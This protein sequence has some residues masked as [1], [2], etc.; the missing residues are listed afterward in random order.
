MVIYATYHGPAGTAEEQKRFKQYEKT[1]ALQVGKTYVVTDIEMGSS[2]T[3]IGIDGVTNE[4]GRSIPF[5][6]VAF[7]F[8]R[9]FRGILWHYD[10]YAHYNELKDY[11]TKV[12]YGTYKGPAGT[13]RDI[14]LFE[15]LQNQGY[16]KKGKTYVV[17]DVDITSSDTRV[18][19]DSLRD[20]DNQQIAINGMAFDYGRIINGKLQPYDIYS[21]GLNSFY[22]KNEP[23]F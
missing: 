1:K 19:L 8:A 6:S 21:S 10:I 12:L 23:Q 16:L 14:E 5:N 11:S 13:E 4:N 18:K 9:N 15:S 17:T 7:T 22:Q 3:S 20:K 2:Y